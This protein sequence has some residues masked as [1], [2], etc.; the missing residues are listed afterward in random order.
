MPEHRSGET[1]SVRT[2]AAHGGTSDPERSLFCGARG[3]KIALR[4][5]HSG[6][7]ERAHLF[8]HALLPETILAA[9]GRN[10]SCFRRIFSS[11]PVP[12]QLFHAPPFRRQKC[13]RICERSE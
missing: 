2:A 10:A 3:Q 7:P 13:K 9:A 12:G 11:V 6:Q 4:R 5:P 1:A 8:A